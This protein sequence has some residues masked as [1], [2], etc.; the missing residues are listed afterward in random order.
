MSVTAML[1]VTSLALGNGLVMIRVVDLW[2]H[3]KV[4]LLAYAKNRI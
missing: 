3:N 4:F 1:A 2:D